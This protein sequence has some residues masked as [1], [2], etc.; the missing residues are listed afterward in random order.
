LSKKVKVR[1]KVK[2]YEGAPEI[3]V[4]EPYQTGE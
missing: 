4:D 1:G 3:I 2:E